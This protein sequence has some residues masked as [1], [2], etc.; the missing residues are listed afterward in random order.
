MISTLALVILSWVNNSESASLLVLWKK[1]PC[2]DPT[3]PITWDSTYEIIFKILGRWS[4]LQLLLYFLSEHA[5]ESAQNFLFILLPQ[6][7]SKLGHL[8]ALLWT[9]NEFFPHDGKSDY[10]CVS[11]NFNVARN[12]LFHWFIQVQQKL[13]LWIVRQTYPTELIGTDGLL[14]S[15]FMLDQ[16]FHIEWLGT[17]DAVDAV[18]VKHFENDGRWRS[19]TSF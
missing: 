2:V 15:H 6:H 19:V 4:C 9:A 11:L 13:L 10:I 16:V 5:F 3:C 14:A 17:R 1:S 12:H 8:P 7:V 18:C